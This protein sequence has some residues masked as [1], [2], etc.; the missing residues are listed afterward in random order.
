M[1]NVLASSGNSSVSGL[2]DDGFI[3]IQHSEKR[4]LKYIITPEGAALRAK[5]TMDYINNSFELYRLIRRRMNSVLDNCEAGGYSSIYIDGD[6]DVADICKL[7]CIERGIKP[8]EKKHS[9][10]PVVKITAL[11]LFFECPV[12][13]DESTGERN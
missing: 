13:E 1:Q 11:K 2:I 10:C 7:T 12:Q 3:K 9:D 6:G 4:K 8:M 5:L